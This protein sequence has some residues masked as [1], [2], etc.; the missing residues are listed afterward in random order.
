M[1]ETSSYRVEVTD[2][3][4][5]SFVAEAGKHTIAVDTKGNGMAPL[6]TFLASLGTCMGYYLRLFADKNSVPLGGAVIRL[7]ASLVRE[8]PLRFQHIAVEVD[9]KG[10][11]LDEGQ[12][13]SLTVYLRSCPVH[14]TLKGDPEI[15]INISS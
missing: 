2:Q 8:R 14:N 10:C 7:S 3:G 4:Y 15:S 12:K 9:T 13:K 11:M 1:V 5:G 6:E